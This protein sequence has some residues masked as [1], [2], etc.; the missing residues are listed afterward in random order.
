MRLTWHLVR[1]RIE[2][3]DVIDV[4]SFWL[5]QRWAHID[6]P[7]DLPDLVRRLL[8]AFQL[9]T[10]VLVQ[11]RTVSLVDARIFLFDRVYRLVEGVVPVAHGF[12]D[13]LGFR[14]RQ[15]LAF[16]I[17][18]ARIGRQRTLSS[19]H[20]VGLIRKLI[21][22]SA[23]DL[24]LSLARIRLT[25]DPVIRRWVYLVIWRL[26]R[27]VEILNILVFCRLALGSQLVFSVS[28]P[29]TCRALDS[30]V[31]LRV[32]ALVVDGLSYLVAALISF[33]H[34]GV[35]KGVGPADKGLCCSKL[36]HLRKYGI[37]TR[38][39]LNKCAQVWPRH[40]KNKRPVVLR[41]QVAIR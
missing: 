21:I 35:I 27:Q 36:R 20:V 40:A 19:K 41:V 13:L 4:E 32:I 5:L 28:V 22:L 23:F 12:H 37:M 6:F 24:Q 34:H 18:W 17:G 10:K 29:Q 39:R 9:V 33:V 1:R 25:V 11:F 7:S 14:V 2:L 8:C 3:S 30:V 26:L 16:Y 15:G 31:R 38:N